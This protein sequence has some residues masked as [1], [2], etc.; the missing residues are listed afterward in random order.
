MG[1]TNWITIVLSP[2]ATHGH[3]LVISHTRTFKDADKV[4]ISIKD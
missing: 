2:V 3:W 1:A 4:T